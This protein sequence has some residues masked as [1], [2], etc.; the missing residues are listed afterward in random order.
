MVKTLVTSLAEAMIPFWCG[1]LLVAMIVVVGVR[2]KVE[3]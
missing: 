2:F 1:I 3:W